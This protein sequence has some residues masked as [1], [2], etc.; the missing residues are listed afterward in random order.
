MQLAEAVTSLAYIPDVPSSNLYRDTDY[1][2]WFFVTFYQSV[3][4]NSGIILLT[5]SFPLVSTSL[6]INLRVS[7]Q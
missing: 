3:L 1:P 5:R 4:A 7:T 2:D 6:L